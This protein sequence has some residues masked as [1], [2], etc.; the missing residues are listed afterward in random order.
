MLL[1]RCPLCL[2]QF[3]P[4]DRVIEDCEV[5]GCRYPVA[6]VQCYQAVLSV[7]V[8]RATY[9][10]YFIQNGNSVDPVLWPVGTG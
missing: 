3:R 9:W 10:E 4:D 6:H 8:Q 7:E 5:F 2:C 1:T